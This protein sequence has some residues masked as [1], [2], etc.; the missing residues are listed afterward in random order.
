MKQWTGTVVV[1]YTQEITVEAETEEAA[2][3]EMFGA[4]DLSKVAHTCECK[5]YD[6]KEIAEST[7]GD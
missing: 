5:A 1:S 4:I 7:T 2:E 3:W 6:V